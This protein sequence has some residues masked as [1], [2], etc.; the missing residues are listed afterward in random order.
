[1]HKIFGA[2]AAAVTPINE[3]FSINKNLYLSH[4]KNLLNQGLDGLGIF[5]TTG[6]ANS[7]NIDEKI[8]AIN[9]LVEHNIKP[10]QLIIGTGVCSIKDSVLLS[11]NAASL[12]SKAVLV[13]PAFYYKNVTN[14]GVIE[15]YRRIIEEVGDNDLNYI[16]YH[17]PKISGVPINFEIIEKLLKL[18]PKNVVGMKD[19]SGDSENMIQVIKSFNDFSLFSGSDTLALK[20]CQH[21]G[22][23]AITATS[24]ISGCL[25]SYIVKNYKNK[26]NIKN[27]DLIQNLQE[28][29]RSLATTHEAI[30]VIKAY[31][32]LNENNKDWN[33]LLPPLKSILEPKKNKTIIGLIEL[34]KKMKNILSHS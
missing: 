1:M 16:L 8:E 9:F 2:Y 13:L 5:G 4:C 3:D 18:Y 21:G 19:S 12:K 32:S 11:K 23:G 20:I 25:L 28:K 22:A 7:F 30:S 34:S 10:S 14:E 26:K 31:L 24:N 29:I 17:F 15:Y 33:R 27:F 6:E